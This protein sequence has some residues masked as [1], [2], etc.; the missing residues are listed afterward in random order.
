MSTYAGVSQLHQDLQSVEDINMLRVS[1]LHSILE[2]ESFNSLISFAEKFSKICN[3][4]LF[5]REWKRELN[6]LLQKNQSPAVNALE[7]CVWQPAM[8]RCCDLLK[9]LSTLKVKL[10]TV[11]SAFKDCPGDSIH[12]ELIEFCRLVNECSG[13]HSQ[14]PESSMSIA[15]EKIKEYFVTIQHQEVAALFLQVKDILK[16]TGDFQDI[17]VIATKVRCIYALHVK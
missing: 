3:S 10:S 17:I 5:D 12:R 9:D 2:Q 1:S 16:L 4:Q 8:T 13:H 11:H 15:A 14:F 6:M 7:G